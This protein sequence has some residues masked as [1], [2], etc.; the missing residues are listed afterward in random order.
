[1]KRLLGLTLFALSLG[2]PA[3]AEAEDEGIQLSTHCPPGFQKVEDGTCELRSLYQLYVSLE[4]GGVGGLKS[5]LPAYR[6]GFTPQQIDLGRYLFF[7]PILSVDGS[8]SC[9]TCHD[10]ELGFS[11]G[12][13]RSVP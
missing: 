1:M 12:R 7:D 10:P 9:A 5:G 11:D 8:I 2:S 3:L 13:G 6:D 4:D